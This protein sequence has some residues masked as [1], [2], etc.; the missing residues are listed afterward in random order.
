MALDPLAVIASLC[1]R[2]GEVLS[3]RLHA[4]QDRVPP[5]D[6]ARAVEKV[7]GRGWGGGSVGARD[8]LPSCV[9][10]CV[11]LCVRVCVYAL[12]LCKFIRAC[13]PSPPHYAHV[14]AALPPPHGDPTPP[15]QPIR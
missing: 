1:G 5:E 11:C 3:L 10:V 4:M 15:R 12:S 8:P 14:T 2:G 6:I 13:V 7:G 9:C